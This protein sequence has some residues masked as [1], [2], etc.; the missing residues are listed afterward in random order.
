MH[1]NSILTISSLPLILSIPILSMWKQRNKE[2][3]NLAQRFTE[4][5]LVGVQIPQESREKHKVP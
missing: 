3:K 2:A 5:R 1:I 4:P